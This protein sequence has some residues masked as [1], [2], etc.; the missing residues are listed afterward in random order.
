VR[1]FPPQCPDGV[2]IRH[3]SNDKLDIN[4]PI[5]NDPSSADICWIQFETAAGT[6]EGFKISN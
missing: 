3:E 5:I 2:P 4:R 1:N 6:I